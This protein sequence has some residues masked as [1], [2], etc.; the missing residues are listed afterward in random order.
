MTA[1]KRPTGETL[2]PVQRTDDRNRACP[3]CGERLSTYNHG[4]Y[5]YNHTA[6]V[7]WKGPLAPR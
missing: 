3:A 5:C 1:G 2:K 4:P 6:A 7:P